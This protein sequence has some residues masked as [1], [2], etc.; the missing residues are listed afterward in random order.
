MMNVKHVP[1]I[2][3]KLLLK[4][5]KEKNPPSIP[6]LIENLENL[7]EE[8]T[9]PARRQS[10]PLP[11][12][13]SSYIVYEENI[14]VVVRRRG[15]TLTVRIFGAEESTDSTQDTNLEQDPELAGHATVAR[16]DNS[17]I[18]NRSFAPTQWLVSPTRKGG[19]TRSADSL[20]EHKSLRGRRHSV[21]SGRFRHLSSP[22]FPS[23]PDT[24]T[25]TL[26]PISPETGGLSSESPTHGIGLFK[27]VNLHSSLNSILCLSNFKIYIAILEFKQA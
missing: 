25:S 22:R 21:F 13:E 11:V 20:Q 18:Y 24:D 27:Q 16:A 23:T 17:T 19:F 7:G 2:K 9:F 14:P 4:L 10:L 5:R 1:S 6:E 3:K 8:E 12:L 15:V 26:S